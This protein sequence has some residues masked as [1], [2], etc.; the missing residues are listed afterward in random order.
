MASYL[1]VTS[2]SSQR[3]WRGLPCDSKCCCSRQSSPPSPPW[4]PSRTYSRAVRERI[5]PGAWTPA[6]WTAGWVDVLAGWLTVHYRRQRREGR[7]NRVRITSTSV[8][9][10]YSACALPSAY[11]EFTPFSDIFV[12][13]SCYITV[14]MTSCTPDDS[15]N[16]ITMIAMARLVQLSL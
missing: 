4:P 10:N 2:W 5:H 8:G 14:C 11:F 3:P 9:Y 15:Q 13:L 1:S 12:L 6:C 16:T 7:H